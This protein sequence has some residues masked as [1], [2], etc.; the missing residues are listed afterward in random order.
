M[1]A[2][3]ALRALEDRGFL[4][5]AVATLAE[6]VYLQGRLGEAEQMTE[7]SETLAFDDDIDAQTRWRA[8]RAKVLARRRQ[9][10]AARQ[11][12]DEAVTLVSKTSNAALLA[13]ALMAKAE[14]SRL[15]G[16]DDQTT[17][18]LRA[19][20]HIYQDRHAMPL[21]ERAKAAL[22]SPTAQPGTRPA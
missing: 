16:A 20:L 18:S 10:P 6:A 22:A 3:E 17:A 5:S 8:S 4:S 21:A 1:K 9:F 19:A 15:A 7:E 2:C 13:E 11:L 14:V 12:A